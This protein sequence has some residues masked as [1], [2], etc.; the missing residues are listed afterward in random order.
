MQFGPCG[1]AHARLSI[2][3]V[4]GSPQPMRVGGSDVALSYNGELYNYRDLRA[5][6]R[7]EGAAF[8]TGGDT[9]V[10]LRCVDRDWERALPR[11]DGM[12]GF[13]AW[14][15]RRE[16]LLLARDPMGVKPLFYA[17]PA[18]GLIVF[19]S[20]IKA[21]LEHPEVHAS[22]D[23]DALR[24]VLRFRAVY[25]ERTLYRGVRQLEPGCWIQFTRDGV[26]GGRYFDL[27]EHAARDRDSIARMED[28]S[29][30]MAEL[31]E[32]LTAAVR[33]RLIADVPV[34]AFLSGGL[35]SSLI[36]ALM[37]ACR[38]PGEEV[39]TFSV[40]FDD[41]PHSELPHARVVAHAAGTVHTEVRV[42]A[43]EYADVLG[44]LTACRDAPLSEPA[45]VAVAR[46]SEVAR[47][48]VKVVLSGEGADEG[49][50]GYPKYRFARVSRATS[51]LVR[52]VGARRAARLAGLAGLDARRALIAA[53]SVAHARE[54]ERF[55]QWFSY[56]ER[57]ALCDLFPNM[58]YEG[59]AWEETTR[60][61]RDALARCATHDPLARMQAVDCLTWLP[62]NLLERGDRMT[63]A[64]GLEMRV[65]FLDKRVVSLGLAM[66]ERLKVRG[67]TGKWALRELAAGLVPPS[68]VGRRKWGF[69]VP[70]ERWF[71]GPLREMVEGYLTSR[72]GLCAAYGDRRRVRD[73]LAAH[74]SG[75]ADAN[76]EL[77]TL[78][79]AEV[80][81]QDV[82]RRQRDGSRPI[83]P[84]VEVAA[85]A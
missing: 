42:A 41:D 85:V 70:L 34:G 78:L 55:A 47:R 61:Q 77:W 39:R 62:C 35:D 25:G 19:G 4:A 50:A 63:M 68:I 48:S 79:S 2:I 54:P 13:A 12:F 49:F 37:R 74:S 22:L 10:L 15:A 26:C 83:E 23:E 18:P 17:T 43:A 66:P 36:V 8:E 14:H 53:R 76:L 67:G 3:D 33:K 16:A 28:D 20:E 24:Q 31:R 60:S 9:E 80:W 32:R 71:R 40:G 27:V 69:R 56:L 6:M 38:S 11:F 45:D 44:E 1:L 65:P 59:E 52:F 29:A 51:A 75:G 5:S 72:D 64:Y 46:M 57:V 58:D 21:L 81:Y 73:L 7:G 30:L 82:F 84:P